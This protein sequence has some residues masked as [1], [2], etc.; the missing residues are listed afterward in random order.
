LHNIAT[1]QEARTD[2]AN[3]PSSALKILTDEVDLKP[4]LD[5]D[6]YCDT[7]VNLIKSSEPR[8][9]IGIY[10]E[11]GTGKTTMMRI[12]ERKLEIEK[13]VVTVWFN[14]WRYEREDQFA[15]IALMKTIAYAIGDLSDYQE[16]KKVLLR[17]LGI[18]GKDILRNVALKYV[19]T[20]KGIDELETNLIP[21]MELL[22]EVDRDTIYFD[23]VKKIEDEMKKI[24]QGKKRIVVFV[25]DLDR[26]SP[27][28]ALEVFESIKV[29]LSMAGFIYVV[30]LSHETISKL[31]SAHYKD[32]DIKGEHYIR[33]I[34]QIPIILPEWNPSDIQQL[35]ESICSDGKLESKYS[36]IIKE[37]KDLISTAIEASPRELKR[38]VN[39]FMVSN[40]IYSINKGIK[41]RDLLTVQALKM[42]WKEFYPYLSSNN[43]SF[44][45]QVA[46][47]LEMSFEERERALNGRKNDKTNPPQGIEK[48]LLEMDYDLWDFYKKKREQYLR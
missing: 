14:A 4:I 48:K 2:E 34:I 7:V 45:D 8:F 20:E 44:R 37:N 22:S 12:I 9:S 18:I 41:S 46:A 15:L 32:S 28:T 25:D 30:G 6:R 3:Y 35:V 43:P 13:E 29:F 21:K 1:N 23:G 31:I 38:F 11:W 10:G 27:K 36:K 19:M 26:C 5:L 16:V 42:R 40:E 47:Y 33:K 17:G 24:V 39:N